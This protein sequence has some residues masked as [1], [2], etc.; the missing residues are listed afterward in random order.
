MAY[1][2]IEIMTTLMLFWV[3]FDK[4]AVSHLV[5]EHMVSIQIW[6]VSSNFYE[7]LNLMFIF[8][9]FPWSSITEA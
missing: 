4:I 2:I 6:H 5:S 1:V 8:L 9:H 3:R 7:D